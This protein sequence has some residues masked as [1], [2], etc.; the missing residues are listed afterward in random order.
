MTLYHYYYYY[1]FSFILVGEG[2]EWNK[3][4]D[5]D[6]IING[7]VIFSRPI[8]HEFRVCNIFRSFLFLPQWRIIG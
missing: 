8:R 2:K 5:A 4:R 7:V 3:Y 1:H 6:Q